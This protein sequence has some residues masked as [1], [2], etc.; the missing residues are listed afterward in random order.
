MSRAALEKRLDDAMEE[1]Q[2]APY[3]STRYWNLIDEI[4]ALQRK[5]QAMR[6]EAIEAA[7]TVRG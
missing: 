2:A 5:V 6:D 7:Q 4:Y 3:R 1:Y